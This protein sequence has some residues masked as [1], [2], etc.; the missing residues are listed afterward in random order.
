MA[1]LRNPSDEIDPGMDR[2]ESVSRRLDREPEYEVAAISALI[3]S[4]LLL[5]LRL[6]RNAPR[7]E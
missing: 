6:R 4:S 7:R 5:A 2:F 1:S 3:S